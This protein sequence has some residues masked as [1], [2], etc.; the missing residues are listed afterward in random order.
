DTFLLCAEKLG[1]APQHCVVF[2]DAEFGLQAARRAGMDVVD[3]RTL[4]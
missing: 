2:E 1:I 4:Y 3:V